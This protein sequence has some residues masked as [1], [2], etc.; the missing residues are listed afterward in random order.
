MIFGKTDEQIRA[1]RRKEREKDIGKYK[2]GYWF[3]WHPAVL[4]D[5]RV[6]WLSVVYRKPGP[7]W[8]MFR[9]WYYDPDQAPDLKRI[10]SNT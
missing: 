1:R 3:A 10:S 7:E 8:S 6:A 4:E 5:G 2:A 9:W